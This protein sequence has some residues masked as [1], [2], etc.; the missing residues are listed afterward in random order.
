MAQRN[1][2][3]IMEITGNLVTI[4]EPNEYATGKFLQ[5]FRMQTD[6]KYSQLLEFKVFGN[7]IDKVMSALNGNEGSD[8][9]VDF[10]L[11]SNVYK[12]K[13]YHNL[14]AYNVQILREASSEDETKR[15]SAP[16]PDPDPDLDE[17]VPF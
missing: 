11:A 17:D 6:G 7:N 4:Y 1:P 2:H 10:N 15:T 9:K 13:V 12:D 3:G 16:D 14:T 8:I 5:A